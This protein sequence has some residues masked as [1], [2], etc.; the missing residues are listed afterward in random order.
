ML[1]HSFHFGHKASLAPPVASQ[2]EP[3]FEVI[4]QLNQK[5][6]GGG[7][8]KARPNPKQVGPFNVKFSLS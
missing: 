1:A 5:Q 8:K 2:A 4:V 7:S 3:T 6:A